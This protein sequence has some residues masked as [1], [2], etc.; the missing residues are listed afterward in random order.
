MGFLASRSEWSVPWFI[1]GWK[2]Q[3][4]GG[5]GGRRGDEGVGVEARRVEGEERVGIRGGEEGREE[6]GK[7]R[8]GRGKNK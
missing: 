5:G 8:R 2:G 3:A 4:G 7:G 1:G 6:Q